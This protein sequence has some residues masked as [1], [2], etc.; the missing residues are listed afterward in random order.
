MTFNHL[1]PQLLG[2]PNFLRTAFT[3]NGDQNSVHGPLSA[4]C[5]TQASAIVRGNSSPMLKTILPF[6][7][8]IN[9]T[10]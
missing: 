6:R 5:L 3:K 2:T 4:S 8:G 10:D 9:A 7:Q 1:H